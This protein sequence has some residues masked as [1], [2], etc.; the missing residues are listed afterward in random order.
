MKKLFL[1]LICAATVLSL[2]SCLITTPGG[3]GPDAPTGDYIWTDGSAVTVVAAEEDDAANAKALHTAITQL[4]SPYTTYASSAAAKDDHE[5]VFG[6]CDRLVS[7][8]AYE[9]L[10]KISVGENEHAY[11]IYSDGSSVCLAYD[12]GDRRELFCSEAVLNY[13]VENCVKA[14]LVAAEGVIYSGKVDF[15]E[16]REELDAAFVEQQWKALEEHLTA[17]CGAELSAEIIDSMKYL[18]TL[19]NPEM[20][21][22][23]A[24][25]YDPEIGGFYYSKSG[26]RT[27]G[28]LPD[29]ESTAQALRIMSDC[30]MF[31]TRYGTDYSK[32]LPE[33]M[34][35]QIVNFIYNLQDPNGYFYHPQWSKA[36]VDQKTSR[37]ARD[38][39]NCTGILA[40]FGVKPKYTPANQTATEDV[41]YLSPLTAPLGKDAPVAVSRVVM[42]AE[43][44]GEAYSPF[45]ESLDTFKIWLGTQKIATQSYSIGNNLTAIY[46]EIKNRDQALGTY[47]PHDPENSLVG[48]LVNWLNVNQNPENGLWHAESNYYGVNGLMKISGVYSKAGVPMPNS[49]KAVEAALAAM[50]T[51]EESTGI[52]CIY[53]T[54]FAVNRVLNIMN[55]Y[56][57]EA[58]AVEAAALRQ[59]VYEAAP[60]ALRVTR[61]KFTVYLKEQGSF[62]YNPDATIANSQGCPVAIAGSVEGD[63]NATCM[64]TTDTL[65]YIYSCLQVPGAAKVPMFTYKHWLQFLDVIDNASPI[66]KEK[67]DYA[68]TVA[69]FD[70]EDVGGELVGNA[71]ATV[72]ANSAALGAT[73]T[74]VED[75]RSGATGNVL[76]I[77]SKYGKDKVTISLADPRSTNCYVFETEMCIESTTAKTGGHVAQI[78]FGDC[79]YLSLLNNGDSLSLIDFSSGTSSLSKNNV[80]GA[81]P[82]FGEWFKL[83]VE[84]Y[85][86]DDSSVRIK[87]YYNDEL[88]AVS[89]NY[90]DQNGNKLSGIGVPCSTYTNT[91]VYIPSKI[92]ATLYLD[93]MMTCKTNDIYEKV[94]DTSL[95]LNVDAS[96]GNEY[97][98]FGGDYYND[99]DYLGTRYDF[100]SELELNELYN[101]TYDSATDVTTTRTP[102]FTTVA[103]GM[104]I[105]KNS[106][107]WQGMT[108]ATKEAYAGDAGDVYV[109][110]TD[111]TWLG[112]QMS[113]GH[114]SGAAF[115]GLLGDHRSSDNGNMFCYNLIKFTEGEDDTMTFF[116]ATLEKGVTYNLRLEYEVGSGAL[117]FYVDGEEVSTTYKVGTTNGS[118][119]EFHGFGIYMRKNFSEAVEF[120]MDNVYMG[121]I[122]N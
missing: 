44:S 2:G 47:D 22:W 57:T 78:F 13:F 100:S 19:Y 109:F 58:D 115:V 120:I 15:I 82:A 119:A 65:N 56:G 69:D 26:L 106:A 46:S 67:G 61:D 34:A 121:V 1:L 45:L 53:N 48:Y 98:S 35:D 79:Y 107:N 5:V 94:T 12:D 88:I 18:Y 30:R 71:T 8:K 84:Y 80:L 25:L 27:E 55:N 122:E 83:R 74:V 111:F 118:D 24:E 114:S 64:G 72:N 68:E 40:K 23:L 16:Q 62:S 20:V 37:R 97:E 112:G 63:V 21:T 95:A 6:K 28:Y 29:A 54:W 33:E 66:V 99:P 81:Y 49:T 91:R 7:Q 85:V 102:S 93:N 76:K 77:D 32:A 17:T 89:D 3:D 108:L 60:E 52:T 39:S 116:G 59:R 11:L 117:T 41:A 38:L 43:E 90:Y 70:D 101:R 73:I 42:A 9:E 10:A 75:T 113:T 103:D 110:E 87:V 105:C 31:Y 4:N 36:L 104:L 14:E 86:G 51:D 50:T 96:Y 92:E